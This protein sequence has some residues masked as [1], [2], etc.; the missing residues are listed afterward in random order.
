MR[1]ARAAPSRIISDDSDACGADARPRSTRSL[2]TVANHG[3][4]AL[5]AEADQRAD[6]LL[7]LLGDISLSI[8]IY[9]SI[10]IDIY[11]SIYIDIYI[12]LGEHQLVGGLVLALDRLQPGHERVPL[13]AGD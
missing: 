1:P 11:I 12:L 5:A 4:S 8:Y 7:A 10:Y 9:I 6:Q 3:A 2:V 13:L